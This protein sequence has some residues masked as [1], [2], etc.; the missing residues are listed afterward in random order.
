MANDLVVK[1]TVGARVE[2]TLSLAGES[3][4]LTGAVVT[5]LYRKPGGALG[6]WAAEVA[7]AAAGVARFV[8][9]LSGTLDTVGRWELQPRV[10]TAAGETLYGDLLPFHVTELLG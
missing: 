9:S 7:D 2:V 3:F 1:G 8:T 5:F 4:D 6:S 10:V